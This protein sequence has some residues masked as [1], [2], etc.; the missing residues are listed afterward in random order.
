VARI[1]ADLVSAGRGSGTADTLQSQV[2]SN[3]RKSFREAMKSRLQL[4]SAEEKF[5][6]AIAGKVRFEPLGDGSGR[7]R[8]IYAK[9][10][11]RKELEEC[12]SDIPPFLLKAILKAIQASG[13]ETQ[14]ENL[15]PVAMALVSPRTFWAVV[16]HGGVGPGR[17][18]TLALQQLVPDV[19]W[20]ELIDQRKRR[21]PE[22]YGDYI[23]H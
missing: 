5:A 23:S 7:L 10:S 11:G 20:A 14:L 15:Q 19:D 22:K 16:R 17:S 18:F 3:L 12:V 1:G 2:L 21:K 9:P 4:A 8:C 13:D 6:A